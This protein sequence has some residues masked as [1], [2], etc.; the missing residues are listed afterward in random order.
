MS[1]R[2][3]ARHS[4]TARHLAEWP[5]GP[6]AP[7]LAPSAVHV[8]RADLDAVAGSVLDGLSWDERDH[9]AGIAGDRESALWSRSRGVLRE[10]LARYTKGEAQAIEL[11]IGS[12]GKPGLSQPGRPELFFNLSHSGNLALYAF[13]SDGPVGVDVQALRDERPRT[14]VDHIG[15]ARRAFG[16][17][18]AQRL[19]LVAPE[20]RER[21]FLRAWTRHEAELKR[22]GTGLGVGSRGDERLGGAAGQTADRHAAGSILEL[23]VGPRAVAALALGRSPNELQLCA[24]T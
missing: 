4:A 21:Q 8:W 12:R 6:Q 14:T 23:D 10:L 19:T 1:D 3:T 15:L 5:A 7:Q 16:E 11:R 2:S 17:H 20:H 13:C 9:A 24:W 22:L 18:E